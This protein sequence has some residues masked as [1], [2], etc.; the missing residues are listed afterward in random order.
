MLKFCL[1]R[2]IEG[3]GLLLTVLFLSATVSGYA[4]PQ[5]TAHEEALAQSAMELIQGGEFAKAQQMLETGLRQ[6]PDNVAFWNLLGIARTELHE[7]VKAQ[8]AFKH[9]L[10]LA[11]NSVSLHEN[12]GL[13]FFKETDYPSAKRYL[14][15][16]VELGSQNPGVK[17]SLAAS[18]LRTGEPARALD[19]L[20][21]LEGQLSGWS[22]YWE[23][24]GRA[25][26]PVDALAAEADFAR[27]IEL[28]GKSSVAFN[29]AASAAE[30]QGLHEKALAYLIRAKQ[31][32]PDDVPTLIHFGSVC[33]RRDLGPD[34]KD[35]LERA[36]QLEPSNNTALFLLARANISLQN[37]QQAVDLFT[38]FIRRVPQ[39]APAYY[40][41]GWVDLR[42][43]K[44]DEARKFLE[45]CLQ[46]QPDLA[47]ARIDLAQLDFEDGQTQ[48]AENEVKRAL[49]TDPKNAKG[50]QLMGD[51]LLRGGQIHEAQLFFEKAIAADPKSSAAHY[52]LAAVL[53]RQHETER[54][55]QERALAT[56]LA[57]ES[58]KESKTQLRLVLPD[59]GAVQ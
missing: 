54:A 29:G 9:G 45:K 41:I 25:E 36:H 31:A 46:L 18:R 24:R 6:S 28:N 58:K 1:L 48:G 57:E 3:F 21:F 5:G 8:E 56:A 10:K 39:F 38:E 20:K 4:K 11:P 53:L 42:L 16:A 44:R 51:L 59:S 52:K 32:N 27:A 17:F 37:W 22:D 23:E 35:A 26:M 14:A 7:P 15:K 34:A 33:I 19:E 49:Q 50:N 55:A 40:A 47:D 13:L 12:A 2:K 43:N 30:K